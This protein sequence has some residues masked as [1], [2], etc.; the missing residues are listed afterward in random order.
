MRTSN[1]KYEICVTQFQ[2]L[3]LIYKTIYL[4]LRYQLWKKEGRNI[5]CDAL[6]AETKPAHEYETIRN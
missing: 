3:S 2:V 4:R 6:C 1:S 5:G